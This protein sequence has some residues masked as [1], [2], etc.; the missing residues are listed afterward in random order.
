[1]SYSQRRVLQE[2]REAQSIIKEPPKPPAN[3]GSRLQS[4]LPQRADIKT[5]ELNSTRSQKFKVRW[6]LLAETGREAEKDCE[7]WKIVKLSESDKDSVSEDRG[8]EEIDVLVQAIEEPHSLCQLST[9]S[10]QQ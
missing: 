5:K 10:D 9:L 7:S 6:P 3:L 1:M 2:C 4:L 8:F